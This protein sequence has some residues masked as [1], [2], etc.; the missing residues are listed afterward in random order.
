MKGTNVVTHM[1]DQHTARCGG[2][3]LQC[4]SMFINSGHTRNRQFFRTNTPQGSWKLPPENPWHAALRDTP[5]EQAVFFPRSKIRI[6]LHLINRFLVS[7]MKIR[8][9][10]IN[11]LL[12]WCEL[13]ELMWHALKSFNRAG[14]KMAG[15][16]DQIEWRPAFVQPRKVRDVLSSLALAEAL[17]ILWY[18]AYM[19]CINSYDSMTI[20]YH[21]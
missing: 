15:C 18:A 12:V 20:K 8:A 3:N 21:Q 17:R 9:L 1:S 4:S 16:I 19:C 2:M 10:H 14:R 7:G 6:C 13:I 11:Q 5:K